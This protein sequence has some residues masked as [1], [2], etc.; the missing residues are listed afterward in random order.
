M[1]VPTSIRPG[2]STA[3]ARALEQ[4]D[5]NIE[6]PAGNYTGPFRMAQGVTAC[7]EAGATVRL[8]GSGSSPAVIIVGSGV[9]CQQLEMAGLVLAENS[10]ASLRQCTI[11]DSPTEGVSV[12]TRAKL[13]MSGCDVQRSAGISVHLNGGEASLRQCRIQNGRKAGLVFSSG[14][15]GTIVECEVSGHGP[16]MPQVMIWQ[17]SGPVL[18]DCRIHSGTGIG[19]LISESARPRLEFCQIADHAGMSVYIDSAAEP[20]LS[21]CKIGPG[22]QNG[23]VVTRQAALVAEGCEIFEHGEKFAQV[24][25]SNGANAALTECIIQKGAG[26]GLFLEGKAEARLVLCTLNGHGGPDVFATA[27]RL[28]L[29]QCTIGRGM[30]T[31]LLLRGQS[32]AVLDKTRIS[33]HP[34]DHAELAVEDGASATLRN[35]HLTDGAGHGVR[36]KSATVRLEDTKLINLAGAGVFAESAAKVFMRGCQLDDCG[37]NGL[38]LIGESAGTVDDSDLAGKST[39]FPQIY[40]GQ[41][42]QLSMRASRIVQPASVGVWFAEGSGGALEGCTIEGGQCGLGATSAAVPRVTGTTIRGV[43]TAIRIGPTGGGI[44]LQSKFYASEGAPSVA[45]ASAATFDQCSFNDSPWQRSSAPPVVSANKAAS[46]DELAQLMTRLNSLIGLTAVK[47]QVRI[48][49]SKARAMRARRLQGLP[50]VTVSYHTVFTGNPG[51]GKTTVAR[52]MG[53]IYKAIGVLPKGHLVECDRSGLVAEFV[54]QTAVKTNKVIDQALG[55]ILFIDEAYTLVSAGQSD[56]GQEAI[57]TLL[58]R[59]ED[60]RDKLIVIVA[61]YPSEMESFLRSNPG[62]RSRFREFIDFPDYAPEEL[63]EIFMAIAARGQ[64]IVTPALQAALKPCLMKLHRERDETYANARTADN[65]FQQI[66]A[67]QAQRI[68]ASIAT[69]EQLCTLDAADLRF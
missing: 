1:P 9:T 37:R 41:K 53:A 22:K 3:L 18:R 16:A 56:F 58:K 67:T 42:S 62:L 61:G 52:L 64:Y 68:D 26:P 21:K 50:D 6:I 28:S 34:A 17:R 5:C 32:E 39:E 54:G 59:M 48:A 31:G 23:I 65:L 20:E 66:L 47:E 12:P 7:A 14:S 10:A 15:R 35:S 25:I 51:T 30:H 8:L 11:A 46:E 4:T 45:Q 13:E 2:D 69:R 36:V 49:T 55:G 24:L 60:D 19:I 57:S 40:V 29:D 63:F 44:F 38:V 27:S 33:G 43:Q